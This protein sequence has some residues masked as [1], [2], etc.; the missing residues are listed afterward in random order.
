MELV[1]IINM[2]C[3][4]K[5]HFEPCSSSTS[6]SFFWMCEE[7][8]QLLEPY[9]P[10]I[11]M[12]GNVDLGSL[13]TFFHTYCKMWICWKDSFIVYFL[14][15]SISLSSCS[16]CFL[17]KWIPEQ[18]IRSDRLTA[19]FSFSW[20]KFIR[21]YSLGKSREYCLCYREKWH[22]GLATLDI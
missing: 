9:Y 6:D 10:P 22:S 3:E 13:K 20:Y 7:E 12:T 1:C 2:H 14:W 8:L 16:L 4:L 5:I 17:E 19:S 21:Y 11:H 15:C 18:C